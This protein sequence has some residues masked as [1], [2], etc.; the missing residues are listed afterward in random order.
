MKVIGYTR[1]NVTNQSEDEISQDV[2]ETEIR[3]WAELNDA[4]E[5]IIFGNESI[6]NK[7]WDDSPVLRKAFWTT[8]KGD[9]LIAY[10]LSRLTQYPSG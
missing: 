2:Q 4:N 5:V 9:C 7:R 10:P 3:A 1:V 8:G 6:L